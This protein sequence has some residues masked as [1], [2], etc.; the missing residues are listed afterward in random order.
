MLAKRLQKEW[1]SF[2]EET[3]PNISAKPTE[4]DLCSWTAQITGPDDS[5]YAGGIFDLDITFT[6][7]YPFQPPKIVFKTPL[8][9]P[10]ISTTGGI[11]L[12]ILKN[13]WSPALSISRV[14]L[15]ILSLLTDPNPDDPYRGEAADLYLKNRKKYE[16]RIR[17]DVK[18]YA[19]SKDTS[20]SDPELDSESNSE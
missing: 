5:P 15:S 12:D 19:I 16:D 10:N 13:K 3:I 9:H 4:K 6:D 11:C 20:T 14:L 7:K 18:K 2:Q 8:F 17:K 1:K